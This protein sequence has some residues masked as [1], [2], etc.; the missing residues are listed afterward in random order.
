MGKHNGK[1][2]SVGGLR[3]CTWV[4]LI[5]LALTLATW[6]IGRAGLGG[7]ELALLV[8]GF[9]LLKGQLVGDHFMGLRRVRGFWRW[10][11]TLWLVIPGGL[12]TTAFVLAAGS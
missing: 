7:L 10:P 8:L 3:P 5:M 4:W 6:A 9:A 1:R 11:V 2:Q 12:I